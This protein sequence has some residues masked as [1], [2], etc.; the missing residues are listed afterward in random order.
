MKKI[1]LIITIFTFNLLIFSNVPYKTYTMG[2]NNRLIETRTAFVPSKILTPNILNAEDLFVDNN[3]NIYIADTG[4]M[5]VL[6]IN[7]DNKEESI[8]DFMMF[9]PTGVYVKND[10]IYVADS[11]NFV[12]QIY[13]KEGQLLKEIDK[14]KEPLFGVKNLFIPLKLAVDDRG[15]IY[16][17]SEGSTNG[18]VNLNEY[19]QF[20]NYF[21]ANQPNVSLK[22]ILQRLIYT[23]NNFLK[24]KPPS[25]TNLCIDKDGLVYTVTEGLNNNSIKKFNV[26]GINVFENKIFSPNK[27]VDIDT[28]KYNNIYVLT[29]EGKIVVLSSEGDLLF[30]FGGKETIYERK[31]L[32]KSPAAIDVGDDGKIYVLDKEKNNIIVYEP[33]EFAKNVFKA[34]M[35]YVQGLYVEGKDLWEKV[36]NLN[37]TFML[38]YKALAK[39]YFKEGNYSKSLEY[40]KLAGVKN[41][42]SESFWQIRNEWLQKNLSKVIVFFVLLYIFLKILFYF[43]SKKNILSGLKIFINSIANKKIVSDILFLKYI[44]KNPFDAFYE[45]KRKN[46]I[47]IYSA[48]ILYGY[49]FLLKI[50]EIYFKG[51]IFNNVN[52]YRINIFSEFI[53]LYTPILLLIISNYLIS[54]INDGEGKLQHIIIGGVYSLAPYL[55][56]YPFLIILSNFI[57]YN[58]AFLINFPNFIIISWSLIILFIMVKEIHNYSVSETVK[59]IFLTLFMV[60]VIVIIAFIIFVLFTQEI[61]F[62][63]SIIMELIVRE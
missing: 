31:G 22:M 15:N 53:G 45:I 40:F 57:T 29:A 11:G 20:M 7:K 56:F 9:M 23:G 14:P 50:F 30:I 6:K 43:D 48:L 37:S 39:A 59:I 25:P 12:V 16:V 54:E 8:G 24:I 41:D 38:A 60:F 49:L 4:N 52:I 10:K 51:Y 34:N 58:E 19:G 35:F 44:L 26:A 46:R 28:D 32:L 5:R 13:D 42:Y 55:I 47:S 17:V 33:T 62:I 63:K 3:G 2:P 27:P 36:K 1:L 21:G 61:D 18:L